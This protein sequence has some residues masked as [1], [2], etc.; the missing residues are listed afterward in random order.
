MVPVVEDNPSSRSLI[1]CVTK[2]PRLGLDFK[3]K[4]KPKPQVPVLYAQRI[5]SFTASPPLTNP[6]EPQHP[7]PLQCGEGSEV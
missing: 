6:N 3:L 7:Y 1:T 4:L 5:T 2:S